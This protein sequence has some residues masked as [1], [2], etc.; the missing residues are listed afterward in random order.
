MILVASAM[1]IKMVP[2]EPVDSCKRFM[3]C[4]SVALAEQELNNQF[5]SQGMGK[6]GSS[7]GYTAKT[8]PSNLYP[9]FLSE[10]EPI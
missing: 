9:F 10:H 5:E 3:N 4:K 7:P 8:T 1:D 6:M 2:D